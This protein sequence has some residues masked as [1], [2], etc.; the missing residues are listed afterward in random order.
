MLRELTTQE[1]WVC[2]NTTLA[3]NILT[4]TGLTDF[5]DFALAGQE[6]L[7]VEL[8]SF[9]STINGRNVE[10]NW[11]TASETNNSGFDIERSSA[12]R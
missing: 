6:A 9:V 1:T 2:Q 5:S 11:S 12:K 3:G 7:P 8:A 4:V 10:L